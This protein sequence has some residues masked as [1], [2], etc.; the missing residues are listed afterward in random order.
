MVSK[1]T[2][3]QSD[4]Q[5]GK[6]KR[7]CGQVCDVV[8]VR[9]SRRG[10]EGVSAV[11]TWR[12][13]LFSR[14]TARKRSRSATWRSARRRSLAARPRARTRT[15]CQATGSRYRARTAAYTRW[16]AAAAA[17]SARSLLHPRQAD[18]SPTS[19]HALPAHAQAPDKY[20]LEDLSTN[21]AHDGRVA[22]QRR[23]A[24]TNHMLRRCLLCWLP[25]FNKRCV[26]AVGCRDGHQ[27]RA[28]REERAAGAQGG[29][30][31]APGAR[32]QLAGPAARVRARASS[33]RL[34]LRVMQ[35]AG[36]AGAPH[37]CRG[38]AR[39][40]RA[41]AGSAAPLL[42]CEGG[43]PDW[44]APTA[45]AMRSCTHPR[46][47]PLRQGEA[48]RRRSTPGS[49]EHTGAAASSIPP[50]LQHSPMLRLSL[51]ARA[52]C[53]YVFRAVPASAEP[54]AA[55][56]HQPERRPAAAANGANG[57][58]S[59]D[60]ASSPTARASGNKRPRA[61]AEEGGDDVLVVLRS[62][63]EVP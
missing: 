16:A 51:A 22:T 63:N 34:G 53:R 44:Q 20:F 5:S 40:P 59:G 27:R 3:F 33:T 7:G 55:A 52:A 31:R 28:R 14:Q 1:H 48:P 38:P 61:A 37:T 36:A 9:E 42:L 12:C 30:P 15:C 43:E 23:V 24:R 46:P 60:P 25:P 17:P 11:P 13:A 54:P 10:T 26:P 19:T 45:L 18:M 56:A 6:G 21:G 49:A 57:A 50:L 8:P 39:A 2:I 47:A 62:T 29:R 35:A 32:Q 41:T 4:S 58:G